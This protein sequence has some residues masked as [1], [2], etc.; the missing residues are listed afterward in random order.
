M[1]PEEA[2]RSRKACSLKD[3]SSAAHLET[4]RGAI[5]L[6]HNAGTDCI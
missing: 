2:G 4:V 5:C 3:S 6:E 1:V